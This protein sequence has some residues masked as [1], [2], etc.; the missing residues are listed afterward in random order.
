MDAG[1]PEKAQHHTDRG[2]HRE[3][4]ADA[5]AALAHRPER[6]ERRDTCG[7]PDDRQEPVHCPHRTARGS[8]SQKVWQDFRR[9]SVE[10][11]RVVKPC[12]KEGEDTEKRY[13]AGDE[14]NTSG[15]N[16]RAFGAHGSGRNAWV[17]PSLDEGRHVL[18]PNLPLR[19]ALAL[20]GE[21]EPRAGVDLRVFRVEGSVEVLT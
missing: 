19:D 20:R 7:N 14:G 5:C 3:Q 11:G 21:L 9:T 2:D 6:V 12:G 4:H 8:C 10:D 13:R 18:Y 16:D 15:T 1:P 17:P